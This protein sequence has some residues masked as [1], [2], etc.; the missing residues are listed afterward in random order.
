MEQYMTGDAPL[1]RPYAPKHAVVT[2]GCGDIGSA[3][4]CQLVRDG[5]EV[6]L[7][8]LLSVDQGEAVAE[9]ISQ[10]TGGIL[11]YVRADVTDRRSVDDLFAAVGPVGVA[12]ANAGIGRSAP[13]LD[14]ELGEWNAHMGTNLTGAF[15]TAQ[16]AARTMREQGTQGLLLFMSS[17]I[18][19]VPWPDMTAYS[20]S[21]A[22]INMLTKQF[23]R[24]LA[25]WGIRSNAIAPGIVRAGMARVQLE[26]EP[27]YASR[28]TRVVPL[29]EFQTVEDVA[30]VVGF[31]CSSSA[32]Y[33]TGTTITADGGASL[34]DLG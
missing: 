18:G 28:A 2:G 14:L 3:I 13:I 34:F 24:E 21:K 22:G 6:T 27:E 29:K 1:S 17:W 12:V 7:A 8:D 25:P 15:N 11:R 5:F 4:A 9:L 31:L 23:A 32:R 10:D 30:A 33:I 20:V 16:V 19:S 26:N